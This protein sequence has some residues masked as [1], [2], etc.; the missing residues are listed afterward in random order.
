MRRRVLLLA[1]PVAAL[2]LAVTGLGLEALDRDSRAA[3]VAAPAPVGPIGA[4]GPAAVPADGPG[5]D[6]SAAT[7]GSSSGPLAG[8][9]IALDPGHDGGN[10]SHPATI[11]RL[12]YAGNGVWKACN[13]TGTATRSG[14]SEHAYAFD[15]VRRLAAL[16]RAQG[17][18]VVLTRSS[19]TGV[20]PCIDR[21]AAIGN[22][23][24]AA[25]VVSVHADGNLAPSARG[26]HIITSD[27]MAGGSLAEARSLRLTSAVR[28][29]FRR[30]AGMP[31]STYTGGGRAHTVRRDL[32]GLNLSRRPAVLIETGNMKHPADARLMR[33]AAFRQRAAA[34]LAAG[35]RT[36]LHR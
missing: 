15:V 13:T 11:N 2:A 10:A 22:A 27:R 23:A 12:V 33:S 16:L 34:A 20:G 31:Y 8:V 9:V 5:T 32:G 14:Y 19:D 30:D 21:R 6:P 18:R 4:V 24:G 28:T 35:I 36:Y 7:A 26:F 29:A 25:V 1:A 3:V 17:A